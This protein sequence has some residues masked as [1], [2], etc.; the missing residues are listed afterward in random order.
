[1]EN[2]NIRCII[3]AIMCLRYNAVINGAENCDCEIIQIYDIKHPNQYHNFTQTEDAKGFLVYSSKERY[4]LWWN[5]TGNNWFWDRFTLSQQTHQNY[6]CL[7]VLND[8]F[9]LILEVE[10]GVA[11]SYQRLEN[12]I[13]PKI[14]P[15]D[16]S[17]FMISRCLVVNPFDENDF[18]ISVSCD[19]SYPL[20][21]KNSKIEAPCIF[22]FKYNQKEY[23]NCT[24]VDYGRLWC[25]TSI[26]EN[27]HWK[28]WGY[29]NEFCQTDDIMN[30]SAIVNDKSKSIIGGSKNMTLEDKNEICHGI[31]KTPCKFPFI[32]VGENYNFCREEKNG[33]LWCGTE[34]S[35]IT[36]SM[37]RDFGTCSESCPTRENLTEDIDRQCMGISKVPCR[38]PFIYKNKKYYSCINE[39][40]NNGFWCAT[41]VDENG[42]YQDNEWL[43]CEN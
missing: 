29:C 39:D 8:T 24:K 25:A 32:H 14:L 18:E 15:N 35:V 42:Q 31:F 33:Y 12:G 28:T 41:S 10:N 6:N 11:S 30:K 40:S 21:L 27:G 23:K 13:G 17:G 16:Q 38:F 36:P 20:E 4:D 2:Y 34:K 43:Y 26:Y 3:L 19:L 1:M 7:G 9:K 5:K 37:T 22:P